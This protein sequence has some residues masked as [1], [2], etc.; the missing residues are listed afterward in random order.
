MLAEKLFDLASARGAG[1]NFGAALREVGKKYSVES[2]V[3]G[4]LACLEGV[5]VRKAPHR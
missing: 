5:A 1:V 3:C 4:V 2:A